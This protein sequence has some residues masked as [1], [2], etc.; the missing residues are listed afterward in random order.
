[1]AWADTGIQ[2]PELVESDEVGFGIRLSAGHVF[3]A[4]KYGKG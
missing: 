4:Y 2:T 3:R 1:M